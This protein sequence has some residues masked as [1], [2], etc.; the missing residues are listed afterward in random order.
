M[1]E[2]VA[3]RL[4]GSPQAEQPGHHLSAWVSAASAWIESTDEHAAHHLRLLHEAACAL[5]R[6]AATASAE[7]QRLAERLERYRYQHF[8]EHAH[9]WSPHHEALVDQLDLA[10]NQLAGRPDRA[11]RG[12]R[13]AVT[14]ASLDAGQAVA[15]LDRRVPLAQLTDLATERTL[16]NFGPVAPH[17]ASAP[18]RQRMLLYA[19]LYVSNE[20]VNYCTYC[21]FRYPCDIVR[22]HLDVDQTTAQAR[23]LRGHGFEHLLL[24]GG[25]FP[26]RNTVSYYCD[27]VRALVSLGGVPGIEIAP[28]S[29]A[30]YTTLAT[31]GV[32]S[33]T[34]YQETYDPQC[35]SKH[36]IR[37]PKSAYQWRLESHD[38][39]AEAGIERLGLGVLLGLADPYEDVRAMLR[40][41]RYLANRFPACRLAFSLPRIHEA[42]DGF[43]IAHPI[44]DELLVRLYAI[45]RI[46]FPEAELIL[47]TREPVPLRNRLA[48][49]CITQMSAGSSTS[50]GGYQSD[51]PPAG[52]QFPV[53]DQ[54]PPAEVVD[55]LEQE[56]FQVLAL[57]N[58]PWR[59][60]AAL[61]N[62]RIDVS[63]R[64]T[65]AK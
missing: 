5:D 20:C 31:A 53:S 10:A 49:I 15:M 19:P 16:A 6:P 37:G 30:A 4:A 14:D 21:G 28:Q 25:D 56:G 43:Q 27:L 29:R 54:R 38:R 9:A 40:H 18:P 46:A 58:R 55:W 2:T 13:H 17:S 41:A 24:V 50:P 39:A 36:H 60:P 7:R 64:P 63:H 32:W 3:I 61:E 62:A 51:G 44:S 23:I 8:N 22:K 34:L 48:R 35:Y 52:Q 59:V 11:A 33:L 12:T 65:A 42:P 47:S 26:G 57:P 1:V 45:L